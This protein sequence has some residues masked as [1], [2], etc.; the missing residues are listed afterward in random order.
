MDIFIKKS[1]FSVAYSDL[2]SFSLELYI[3]FVQVY[4]QLRAVQSQMSCHVVPTVR[5]QFVSI[6]AVKNFFEIFS[7]TILICI[8]EGILIVARNDRQLRTF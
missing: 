4:K 1:P 2:S 3:V 7:Q 6:L 8:G 5:L